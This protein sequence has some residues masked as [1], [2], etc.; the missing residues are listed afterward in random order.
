MPIPKKISASA[1]VHTVSGRVNFVRHNL[2]DGRLSGRAEAKTQGGRVY[3]LAA[4]VSLL[5]D[6]VRL[7]RQ[8]LCKIERA[9][10]GARSLHG[11]AELAVTEESDSNW[12]RMTRVVAGRSDAV[13]ESQ[14][15]A[16]A[17]SNPLCHPGFLASRQIRASDSKPAAIRKVRAICRKLSHLDATPTRA[18][19][20]AGNQPARGEGTERTCRVSNSAPDGNA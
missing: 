19:E 15:T 7:P 14:I 9:R 20:V 8:G 10:R 4:R 12:N 17:C 6:E 5:H 16:A 2:R 18:L 3:L 13:T 1:K 11:I